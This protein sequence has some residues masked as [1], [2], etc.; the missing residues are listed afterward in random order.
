MKKVSKK[1][2]VALLLLNAASC[3]LFRF[4]AGGRPNIVRY[5]EISDGKMTYIIAGNMGQADEASAQIVDDII[6]GVTFVNYGNFG[7][8]P[9]KFIKA[10]E[11][12]ISTLPHDTQVTLVA[13]SLGNQVAQ[14]VSNRLQCPLYAVNPCMGAS[15]PNSAMKVVCVG[16]AI[17]GTPVEFGLGWLS[18]I[19]FS[20]NPPTRDYSLATLI[21]QFRSICV[22]STGHPTNPALTKVVISNDDELLDNAA[23]EEFFA[24]CEVVRINAKHGSINNYP[25]AYRTALGQLGLIEGKG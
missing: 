1:V 10:V 4:V 3:I 23:V 20:S 15:S 6:G 22:F 8:S 19:P 17:V 16:I 9:S 2:I 24:G 7:Y 21:D 13:I 11:N 5:R 18:C 12:D 14:T 25:D